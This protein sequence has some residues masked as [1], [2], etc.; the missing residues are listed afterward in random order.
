MD[1]TFSKVKGG[2]V[3]SHSILVILLSVTQR[4]RNDF[5]VLMDSG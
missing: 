5:F 1:H 4:C 3:T 2:L